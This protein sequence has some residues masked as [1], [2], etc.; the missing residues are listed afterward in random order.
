MRINTYIFF[1]L[2]AFISTSCD[3]ILSKEMKENK[4]VENQE[5]GTDRFL[6]EEDGKFGY[7]NHLG[8]VVITPQFEK[9]STSFSEGLANV[10]V[11]GRWGFIDDAG[12]FV[13]NPQ[14]EHTYSFQDHAYNFSDGMAKVE[15]GDKWGYIDKEGKLVV[16]PQF[17]FAEDFA[18]GLA[19]V[20]GKAFHDYWGF[21]DKEG[22]YAINP[23]FNVAHSFS[24]GLAAVEIGDIWGF[25]D[26]DGRYVINPQFDY[27]SDFADGLA[28]VE[29]GG[30]HGIIN[31]EGKYII[32]PQFDD[33]IILSEGLA[34]V[35]NGE[36]WGYINEEGVYIANLQFDDASCF[37]EGL[38]AVR[39][40]EKW[41]FVDKEGKYAINPQFDDVS[42]FNEN[43]GLA[44]AKI[45][46]KWGFIDMEGKYIINPQFDDAD[47]FNADGLAIVKIGGKW[48]CIDK[49]G[50]YVINPLFDSICR[51]SRELARAENDG[52]WGYINKEGNWVWQSKD[53]ISRLYQKAKSKGYST[54]EEDFRLLIDSG[55]EN[56]K[57]LY[58]ELKSLG[59]KADEATFM[60]YIGYPIA[61]QNKGRSIKESS[62]QMSATNKSDSQRTKGQNAQWPTYS[63]P[64]ICSISVPSTM[65]LRDDNSSAG[66]LFSAINPSLYKLLCEGC[67]VF[68]DHSK[69]VFQPEGMNSNS[70]KDIDRATSTYARIIIEF[71]YNYDVSQEDIKLMTTVD[72]A[73]YDDIIGKQYKSEFDYAQQALGKTGSFVWH[74]VKREKL[75]GKYCL[76]LDYDRSGLQGMVK[77]KKYLFYYNGKE[78]DITCSYRISEKQKYEKDFEKVI[79]SIKFE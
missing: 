17:D 32:N 65:E 63:I 41:G 47:W 77:V 45:D 55:V 10:K 56:R 60:E 31:K 22:K 58:N 6:I 79:R 52:R 57:K 44:M 75:G 35:K 14:F 38:A 54:S 51:F 70:L 62:G 4:L 25:I 21:I 59:F 71:G 49:D 37:S 20:L 12:K 74:P 28:E 64:N 34:A 76:I 39:I 33:Y 24:E 72:L 19:V 42:D 40:G 13:I 8:E 30:K 43:D 66:K 23:Q 15:F 26:K 69:I 9:A 53:N 78:V 61:K 27:V 3:S 36:K 16:T 11:G 68:S 73:E 67:D 1:L 50:R 48:G 5:Q 29:I 18:E 46:G 2:I 7:I